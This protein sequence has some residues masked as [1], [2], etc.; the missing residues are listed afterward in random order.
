MKKELHLK[1]EGYVFD[2]P[3]PLVVRSSGEL[4]K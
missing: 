4:L 2:Y 1:S 3:M